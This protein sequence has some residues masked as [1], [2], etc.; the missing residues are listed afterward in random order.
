MGVSYIA[1]ATEDELSEAIGLKMLAAFCPQLC[2]THCFRGGGN[3]YLRQRYKNF[4]QMA[5]RH[6]VLLITDL[7]AESCPTHLM[8]SWR[9]NMPSSSQLIFRIAVREI[10][11]WLLADHDAM[12]LLLEKPEVALPESPDQ[13][14][15]P[16]R[17]LLSLAGKAPRSVREDLCKKSGSI[18]SQGLGYNLRLGELVR[19]TWEPNRAAQR[20]KSLQRACSQLSSLV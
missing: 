18:A 19:S 14:A 15:D 5:R 8:A 16:K 9:G 13:L 6:Y 4:H 20:S 17:E 11:S 3:G 1:L 10:E 2:L 7:D 12:R